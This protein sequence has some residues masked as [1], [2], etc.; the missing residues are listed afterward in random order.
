MA[1]PSFSKFYSNVSGTEDLFKVITYSN[2]IGNSDAASITDGFLVTSLPASNVGTLFYWNP[3][4]NTGAGD[5]VAVPANTTNLVI[6]KAAQTVNATDVIMTTQVKFVPADNVYGLQTAFNV[7]A[8]DNANTIYDAAELTSSVSTNTVAVKVNLAAVNDAPTLVGG[9]LNTSVLTTIT[10]D[11]SVAANAGQTVA[12]MV[13]DGLIVDV[14]VVAGTA[15]SE[16]IYVTD[17]NNTK[18]AWQFKV[19]TGDWTNFDFSGAN[20]GK[21]LLL[22]ST[23]MVRFLPN[24]NES[25]SAIITF[26][27]W[28]RTA[29]TAGAYTTISGTAYS[30][31]TNTATINVTAVN[32]PTSITGT[33][34]ETITDDTTS[35]TLFS[36][37]TLSDVDN[38]TVTVFITPSGSGGTFTNA[39]T[40]GF[41]DDNGV[42]SLSN[43]TIAD[44]QAKIR[45]LTFMPTAD[46]SSTTTFAIEVTEGGVSVTNSTTVLI[47]NDA[48]NNPTLTQFSPTA[49]LVETGAG[50]AGVASSSITLTKADSD[51]TVSYDATWLTTTGGWETANG[52]LTYTK[53][54]TYGTATLTVATDVVSYALNNSD[55]DTNALVVGGASVADE[56]TVRIVDNENATASTTAT[57]TITGTNDA[58][59]VSAALAGG[60]NEGSS[61]TS[62]NLLTGATDP[63]TAETA[64]LTISGVTYTVNGQLIG[65]TAPSGVSLSGTTLSIDP[66]NAIFNSLAQGQTLTL[67]VNYN[68]VDAHSASVAQTATL[69]MTGT[70][71]APTVSNVVTGSATEGTGT[72]TVNLLTNATDADSGETASLSVG[73]VT[74]TVGGFATGNGGTDLPT[75]VTRSGATLSVDTNNSVFNALAVGQTMT[76]VVGYNVVDAQGATV[77]QTATLTMTGTN[78]TPVVTKSVIVLNDGLEQLGQVTLTANMLTITDVDSDASEAS[79]TITLV[80]VPNGLI[81]L[82]DAKLSGTGTSGSFT[83]AD[84]IAGNVKYESATEGSSESF[85]FTVS[86]AHGATTATQTMT[87]ALNLPNIA[88]TISNVS[89]KSTTEDAAAILIAQAATVN[90]EVYRGSSAFA[91]GFLIVSVQAENAGDS[92]SISTAGTGVTLSGNDVLVSGV[93]IGAI[94]SNL[95]GSSGQDLKI[96]FVET[97]TGSTGNYAAVASKSAVQTL[98]KAIAYT[99]SETNASVSIDKIIDMAGGF[100]GDL[101]KD[102][103]TAAITQQ[104]KSYT[105][106]LNQYFENNLFASSFTDLAITAIS[107]V[108]STS[109]IRGHIT[110]A[111]LQHFNSSLIFSSFSPITLA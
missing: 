78:D 51:G 13:A 55:T 80:N 65:S 5:W 28:D 88:P 93:K 53:L 33:T 40:L 38:G 83:L 89:S 44:A 56:F 82:N 9:S 71:D 16:S 7:K 69:T 86:D 81:Y 54:G 57:F 109:S 14:D 17:V 29:G 67:L 84:V 31:S 74:Y 110:Y 30:A 46:Q 15:A 42:L 26:G 107:F 23:D 96:T 52:G 92:L 97:F 85:T 1:I 72:A 95:N 19:G 68:V 91:G 48:N 10:E 12:S 77:A 63:D 18:G 25:G 60:A 100:R 35:S 24:L 105:I 8:I 102:F 39:V 76:M 41:T 22:N 34:V 45:A 43:V 36:D 66:T 104:D 98:V 4:L 6:S 87:A 70:N 27:A 59:V 111:C 103:F 99:T 64:G 2:L 108:G 37:V 49:I 90:N 32:D 47:V 79:T 94:D 3:T 101:K 58:P 20:Q 21:A 11:V 73:S 106:S 62:V 61:V 50:V 75:G